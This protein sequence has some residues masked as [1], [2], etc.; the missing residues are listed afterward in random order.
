MKDFIMIDA[1]SRLDTDLL[2]EHFNQKLKNSKRISVHRHRTALLIASAACICLIAV[3]V[4]VFF[5]YIANPTH[6]Q[7]SLKVYFAG[8]TMQAGNSEVTLISA[9][10]EAGTCTFEINNKKNSRVYLVFKGNISVSTWS[11]DNGVSFTK[12][13]EYDVITPTFPYMSKNKHIVID[14]MLKITVNGKEVD[15]I[16]SKVGIYTVVID[17]SKMFES[18]DY[19]VAMVSVNDIASFVLDKELSGWQ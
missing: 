9:D 12:T 14:D 3:S 15:R 5:P 13:E 11:D 16:P 7:E 8:E 4:I 19:V 6:A 18:M 10:H 1:I 2:T 17:Y